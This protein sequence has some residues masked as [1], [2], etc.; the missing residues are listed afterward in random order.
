MK[1]KDIS[2]YALADKNQIVDEDLFPPS[3]GYTIH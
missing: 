2:L 1:I 3:F